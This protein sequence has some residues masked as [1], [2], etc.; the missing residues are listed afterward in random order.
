MLHLINGEN[1]H[2]PRYADMLEQSYRIRH[3]IYVNH[4]G[5]KALTRPDGR[6]IDQFDTADARYLMW[7]DGDEVV[8]GAR[9]VPTHLPH[10]MSDVFP[11]IVT[12]GEIPKTPSVWELTRMFTS[13]DGNSKT[14]RRHVTGDVWAGMF[15]MG[16]HYELNAISIVCDT[17]FLTR[18]LESGFS[19][20]PL[21]L[22]TDYPEGTCIAVTMPVTTEQLVVARNGKRGRVLFDVEVPAPKD[23]HD[24]PQEI[25]AA[26]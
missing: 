18:F 12:L 17:F 15:E 5:W 6:E 20:R 23:V 9:F 24:V 26:H 14:N 4:R 21:G 11:H 16:L 3:D 13:R 19:V 7:T 1:R 2:L 22:P 25:Y 10:L 8:G